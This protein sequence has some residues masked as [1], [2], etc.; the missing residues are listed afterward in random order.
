LFGVLYP[1]DDFLQ[2]QRGL[3]AARELRASSLE[4][5]DSILREPY[6]SAVL[7]LV[8][9]GADEQRLARAA[10]FHQ[11]QD[12]DYDRL[13]RQLTQSGSEAVREVARFHEAEL[14]SAPNKDGRA[15]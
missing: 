15:A 12:L 10:G 5:I 4:L 14:T 13:L 9:D 3:S 6:R 7:A 11:P 2:I 1:S 8:D